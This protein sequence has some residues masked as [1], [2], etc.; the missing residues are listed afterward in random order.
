M[1]FYFCVRGGGGFGLPPLVFLRLADTD[2]YV[3]GLVVLRLRI[4]NYYVCGLVF[5]RLGIRILMFGG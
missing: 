2:S 3:W 1:A 5:L 4:S